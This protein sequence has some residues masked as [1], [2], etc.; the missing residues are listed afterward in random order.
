MVR[1]C[2]N[3]QIESPRW[4][5]FCARCGARCSHRE[6]ETNIARK[7]FIS[8]QFNRLTVLLSEQFR[9]EAERRFDTILSSLAPDDNPEWAVEQ[10]ISFRFDAALNG[11]DVSESLKETMDSWLAFF[12]VDAGHQI[13]RFRMPRTDNSR[14]ILQSVRDF[15]QTGKHDKLDDQLRRAADLFLEA[16]SL[17]NPNGY[18][19]LARLYMTVADEALLFLYFVHPHHYATE[20]VIDLL[21][22]SEGSGKPV[23]YNGAHFGFCWSTKLPEVEFGEEIVWLYEEAKHG[24]ERALRLDPSDSR[25]YVELSQVL[26]QLGQPDE[27]TSNL[28]RALAILNKA[29]QASKGD[30]ESWS[31]RGQVFEQL[32]EID[33]AISDLEQALKLMAWEYDVKNLRERVDRLRSQKEGA[34]RGGMS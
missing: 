31:Q 18:A 34:T 6:P 14:M 25:S 17:R 33:L 21:I 3:C 8:R 15:R 28:H 22:P 12:Y 32:G 13:F 29:I 11:L 9:N 4:Q 27:A 10:I 19:G 23:H 5:T 30:G 2:W 1:T 20:R 24:Y 7:G 26:R 16:G